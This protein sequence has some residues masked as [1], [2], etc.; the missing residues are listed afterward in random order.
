MNRYPSWLNVLVFS[1]LLVGILIAMPNIYGSAPAVQL[2][3]RDGNFFGD[4]RI[5]RVEQ[6]LDEAGITPQATYLKDGRIVVRFDRAEDQEA[7][8]QLFRNRFD[9]DTN[10]A[11]TMAPKL[12]RCLASARVPFEPTSNICVRV[13]TVA[14]VPASSPKGS[15]S[16]TSP[17]YGSVLTGVPTNSKRGSLILTKAPSSYTS[18]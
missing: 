11:F 5:A 12:P 15:G 2:A 4:A 7:A 13:W 8:G 16:V 14:R 18:V 9:S 17:D 3:Q 6:V 1:I 10:V